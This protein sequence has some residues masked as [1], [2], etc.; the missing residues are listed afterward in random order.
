LKKLAASAEGMHARVAAAMA[1]RRI[2]EGPSID[3]ST[4]N[5]MERSGDSTVRGQAPNVE[6]VLLAL[7]RK[8]VEIAPD[9]SI[10]PISKKR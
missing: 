1:I 4:L 3:T 6:R 7:E 8:G 9:G 5:R 10:R 2:Q